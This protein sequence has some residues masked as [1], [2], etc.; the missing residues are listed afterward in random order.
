MAD[1]QHPPEVVP[2]LLQALTDHDL[3]V[4]SRYCKGGSAGEWKLSRKVVSAVAN[5]LA[6]PLAPKVKD[7]MSGFFAF[8]RAAVKPDSLNAVGCKIGLEVAARGNHHEVTEVP[9]TFVPR[10]QVNLS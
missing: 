10:I 3:V 1:L 5:L 2:D 7:R 9:S 8:H 4:G 6:L